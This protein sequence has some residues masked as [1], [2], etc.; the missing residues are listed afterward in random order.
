MW[1]VVKYLK[2]CFVVKSSSNCSLGGGSLFIGLA[3]VEHLAEVIWT[4]WERIIWAHAVA[5]V[6]HYKCV[7]FLWVFSWILID[8]SIYNLLQGRNFFFQLV[9]GSLFLKLA[10]LF[11]IGVD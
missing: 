8:L 9:V 11:V 3:L 1:H 5:C 2:L 10:D 7:L 6:K 4:T